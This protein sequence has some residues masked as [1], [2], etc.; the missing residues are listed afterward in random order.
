MRKERCLVAIV[1]PLGI[2]VVLMTTPVTQT[3]AP[4][5]VVILQCSV[6]LSQL[7]YLHIKYSQGL[8]QPRV[9]CRVWGRV[10]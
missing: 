7:P 1:L 2:L 8:G 3:S 6:L 10:L 9:K 4:T 5:S